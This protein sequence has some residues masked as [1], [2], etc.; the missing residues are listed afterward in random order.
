MINRTLSMRSKLIILFSV[1]ILVPVLII[2]YVMPAY[3]TRLITSETE[4]LTES[5]LVGLTSN[6]Q[7][8]LDELE[9]V[10]TIPYNYNEVMYALK[11]R[12]S[13]LYAGSDQYTRYKADYALYN[14]L[15]AALENMHKEILGTLLLPF[16]GSVFYKDSR[17]TLYSARTDYDYSAQEWYQD[18]VKAGGKSTFVK[19][20]EQ[21][22][23]NMDGLPTVFSVARLIRDMDTRK[24]IAVIMADADTMVID[25]IVRQLIGNDSVVVI[26]DPNGQLVYAS[27]PV[28]G[29]TLDQL[30]GSHEVTYNNQT[31]VKVS[32]TI[33]SSSW[34]V[35]SL[36][37]K[38]H[39]TDKVQWMHA[40][41]MLF[42]GAG[43]VLTLFLF[44][45]YSRKLLTP[46]REMI[47]VMRRVQRGDM[48]KRVD[49]HGKDEVAELGMA[50]N[51]MIGRLD[52]MVISEY[53][54]RL[55][56]QEAEMQALQAQIKPHFLYNTLN[57]FV[58]LNRKGEHGK[59]DR[60]IRS[61]SG[62]LRYIQSSEMSIT[63][64]E[65]FSILRKY[66]ELQT[67]RFGD[68]LDF[69]FS[70]DPSLA[71]LRIPKLLLQPLVENSV[72]HGA[73]P[74]ARP[75]RVE[76]SAF[77][78]Q[79]EGKTY[80]IIVIQDDG[81]GFNPDALDKGQRIGLRSAQERL[82]LFHRS[83]ASLHI[84]SKPGQG[85]VITIRIEREEEEV[86]V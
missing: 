83:Q 10:T 48:T 23:I 70:L 4:K 7:Y 11:L 41:G 39:F 66:A 1:T 19:V 34:V 26:S 58:G 53:R 21:D 46:F 43:L 5:T 22:Y 69:H 9:R 13:G 75:C 37:P 61:L 78:E 6:I 51:R 65:E 49:I 80:A 79:A 73:E 82:G 27:H 31:Y 74:C 55:K 30:S 3:Y 81:M 25:R 60:A 64:E 56:Q 33:E 54:A 68:R 40:A 8:Y 38:S 84:R 47:G 16:D 2:A 52:E 45:A 77:S 50:L 71:S 85:T 20:H 76:I 63:L 28:S 36:I 57:G 14:T 42:A 29:E 15:P 35:T 18:A 59:L 67:M 62:L 72:V 17:S 24:P 86:A 12:S 32:Q 44:L